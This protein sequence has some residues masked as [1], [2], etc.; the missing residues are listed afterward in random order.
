MTQAPGPRF[1]R[2]AGL[3]LLSIGA[4]ALTG[5][6]DRLCDAYTVL[7]LLKPWQCYLA[8]T[9]TQRIG[10]VAWGTGA[11]NSVGL[12]TRRAIGVEVRI[13]FALARV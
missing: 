3:L 7:R 10:G 12:A 1:S 5:P 8:R 6:G 4:K 11:L 13:R 2:S 9:S